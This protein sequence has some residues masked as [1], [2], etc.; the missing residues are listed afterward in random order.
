LYTGPKPPSPIL[1]EGS[2]SSVAA[3]ICFRENVPFGKL[4][5][6]A[7]VQVGDRA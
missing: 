1:L 6:S 2:K 4:S 5:P 7:S 3:L